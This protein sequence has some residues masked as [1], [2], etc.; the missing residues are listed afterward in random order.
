MYRCLGGPGALVSFF[1]LYAALVRDR[2]TVADSERLSFANSYY[3]LG[4]D[5]KICC[6]LTVTDYIEFL[7]VRRL[8]GRCARH[9]SFGCSIHC[10]EEYSSC[11]FAAAVVLCDLRDVIFRRPYACDERIIFD[12]YSHS[13]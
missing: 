5:I 7:S 4:V 12:H 2:C 3:R 8:V 9:Y 1:D 13:R 6:K 10:L 11:R